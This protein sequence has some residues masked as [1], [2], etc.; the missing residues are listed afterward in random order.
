MSRF[1]IQWRRSSLDD[2]MEI[3][4]ASA[5]R[6]EVTHAV[7][8]LET[9][10]KERPQQASD[11]QVEGLYI[12]SEYPLRIGFTI[13]VQSSIVTVVGIGKIK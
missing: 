12:L 9:K 1:S 3:W 8:M 2:L 7:E 13:D 10:L 6:A 4:L 5:D 11:R